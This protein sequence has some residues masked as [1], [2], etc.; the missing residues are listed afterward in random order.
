MFS[1]TVQQNK[2]KNDYNICSL[3]LLESQLSHSK[4]YMVQTK[5]EI[6]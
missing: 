6:R 5:L 4:S 2:L 3:R 1:S